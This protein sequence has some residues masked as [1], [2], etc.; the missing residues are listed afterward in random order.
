MKLKQTD[1]DRL[2][3][4]NTP[5]PTHLR[6]ISASDYIAANAAARDSFLESLTSFESTTTAKDGEVLPPTRNSATASHSTQIIR[7]DQR[8][9]EIAPA[10][11]IEAQM[12]R[13]CPVILRGVN[14]TSSA[15]TS[16][17]D[18]IAALTLNLPLNELHL[19]RL[20]Y[21]ADLL[22]WRLFVMPEE[23]L[24]SPQHTLLGEAERR[25]SEMENYL[26]ASTIHLSYAEGFPALPDGTPLWAKLPHEPSDHY[27]SFTDYCV[28][29]G[30]RQ[31]A[32]LQGRPTETYL[33]WFHEDYWAIR[34]KCYDMVGSIHAAKQRELR[35]LNCED[36]HYL[37]S[38]KLFKRMQNL[39]A[40]VDWDYLKEDPKAFVD[41]LE[42]I[43]KLQRLSI[44]LSLSN[45]ANQNAAESK[46]ES[47]E[48]TM[49]KTLAPEAIEAEKYDE[50]INVKEL[51]KSP[52]ALATA[53]ELVIRMTRTS[54]SRPRE[55]EFTE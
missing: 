24:S 55:P 16:R 19:P 14:L 49:R 20:I 25:Y 30:M 35:I 51:L 37:E 31:V 45:S 33:Q 39:S 44:G 41:V 28:Q 15:I 6:N 17:S 4:E 43:V 50:A 23:L 46:V 13:M 32:R 38:Q 1:I 12:L 2:T 11:S 3:A 40:E 8:P 48:V 18:L 47:L 27:A 54:E 52:E 53:Q 9:H 34:A 21:R 22:D 5:Q 10:L 7:D 26:S 36:D 42:K 29:P